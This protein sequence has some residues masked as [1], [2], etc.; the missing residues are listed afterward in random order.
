MRKLFKWSILFGLIGIFV[1]GM[2]GYLAKPIAFLK[3]ETVSFS[4]ADVDVTLYDITKG[5]LIIVI[6]FWLAALMVEFIEGKVSKMRRVRSSTRTLIVKVAQILIYVL[7]FLITLDV[8]GIDLTVLTVFSGALGIG[9]G[10]GL[11]K[12][13]SNFMSGLILLLE[14]SVEEA[15]LIELID[16]TTGYIRRTGAR[17]TLI[18]TFDCR[19]IMIPNEDFI[20]SRVINWTY[21][22]NRARVD[23]P[24]GIMYDSDTEKAMALMLEAAKEH[25]LCA[26]YPPPESFLRQWGDSSVRLLLFFWIE[27]VTVGRYGIQSTVMLNIQKKFKEHGIEI[28]YPQRDIHIKN[29][30]EL[31]DA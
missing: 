27:D 18:E 2:Q 22:N 7:A 8:I 5:I 3:K 4:S 21:S 15:D 17:F 12:I 6:A 11:Q 26:T 23:I 24:V 10:F 1:A 25:E 16:G 19:E 29:I 13:A 9:L 28:A 31:K 30:A 14:K 20:T